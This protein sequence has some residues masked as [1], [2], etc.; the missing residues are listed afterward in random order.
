VS[1]AGVTVQER[2]GW[3]S[4]SAA[5]LH[6]LVR[7]DA[8]A[9]ALPRLRQAASSGD[10]DEVLDVLAS[11]GVR[12]APDFVAVQEGVPSRVVVRGGAY[13]VVS[14]PTGD[15][16][17]RST[18]RGPW[19][20]ED[21][22]EGATAISLRTG[23]PEPEPAPA[24][25][26]PAQQP[27]PS[28]WRLPSRLGRGRAADPGPAAPAPTAAEAEEVEE[29]PSYD[30]LFGAT[31]H[32]RPDP[33]GPR[34][35]EPHDTDSISEPGIGQ[36][37]VAAAGGFTEPT[38]RS[39]QTLPPPADT[40]RPRP[41][42]P[43]PPAPPPRPE[44]PAPAS[45]APAGAPPTPGG[46]IDSVPWRS[47]GT[48]VAAPEPPPK[49]QEPAREREPQ[50]GSSA[51][52][53]GAPPAAPLRPAGVPTPP[54]TPTLRPMA[55]PP[56]APAPLPATPTAAVDLEDVDD[57]D[58]F[59]DA[60]A[61]V[62]RSALLAAQQVES[63]P[64]VPAVLCP[65]GHPSPPHAGTCRSCGR[66]IP[67]QQPF[68]TARPPLGVLRLA[69]GDVVTLDRGVLLGRSPKVRADVPAAERPHLVKVPSPEN[70]ISR[71]H[72]EVV[73]EGWHVLV[74]DL[75]STNGTTVALPGQAPVRLRPGDQ[76][77]IE[78]GTILSLADEVSLTFEVGV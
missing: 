42:S 67:V 10:L 71:N 35:I 9:P 45:A 63:G 5:C 20:D 32:G 40:E 41:V 76:Q 23:D 18:G 15:V 48:N 62:D 47:G 60:E 51:P 49:A 57:S 74:R 33:S 13:A 66:E 37:P 58:D 34:F 38:S 50:T 24:P 11:A 4:V 64:L 25:P 44:R 22:P 39:D 43:P 31:Q 36:A 69:T 12:S 27:A 3:S 72:L 52:A 73:L 29:L 65:A 59:D 46:L 77:V 54:P 7:W 61:T 53:N 1:T 2:R 78:P 16:T 68:Q 6:V 75:G 14:A 30:H 28:G 17:V 19:T 26:A 55:P 8:A 56:A 70:D 21:A